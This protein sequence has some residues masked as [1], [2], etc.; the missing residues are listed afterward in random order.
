MLSSCS[1]RSTFSTS[2]PCCCSA[3]LCVS[4]FVEKLGEHALE[5][6][7]TL[8]PTVLDV[9]ESTLNTKTEGKAAASKESKE[10][11]GAAEGGKGSKRK[12]TAAGE[13]RSLSL[14]FAC[15]SASAV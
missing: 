11:K 10:A 15:T 3:L 2:A 8:F 4:T 1:G 14:A 9:L 6:L 13:V 7:P 5:H 12:S